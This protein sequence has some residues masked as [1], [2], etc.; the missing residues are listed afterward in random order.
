MI[1]SLEFLKHAS[2]LAPADAPVQRYDAVPMRLARRAGLERAQLLV[3]SA[4]RAALQ[5]FLTDWLPRLHELKTP[6]T[7]H[8]HI[9]VD[10]IEL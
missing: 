8:W 2:G 7:L 10:P 5:A 3:E 4:S 9:E 1:E 6:R